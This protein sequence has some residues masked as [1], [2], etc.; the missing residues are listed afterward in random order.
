MM[1]RV[2]SWVPIPSR[3][4]PIITR[5]VPIPKRKVS[6]PNSTHRQIYGESQAESWV[7]SLV[8][9]CVEPC[10]S[11]ARACVESWVVVGRQRRLGKLSKIS[12]IVEPLLSGERCTGLE[13]GQGFR[14]LLDKYPKYCGGDRPEDTLLN[15][16]LEVFGE[17][18]GFNVSAKV[19][20]PSMLTTMMLVISDR[21]SV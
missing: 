7:Q 15:A 18:R 19:P 9:S 17:P 5:K 8:P 4:V 12:K 21:V 11:L 16:S 13:G 20:T 14:L 3:K 6:I 1:P 2:E 10:T